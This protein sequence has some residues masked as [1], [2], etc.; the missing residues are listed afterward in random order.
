MWE[1]DAKLP[2][3]LASYGEPFEVISG[4][5]PEDVEWLAAQA[6][7]REK[8]GNITQGVGEG[9]HG[10]MGQRRQRAQ[11][12]R[13]E[14]PLVVEPFSHG[15]LGRAVLVPAR[16]MV[17]EQRFVEGLRGPPHSVVRW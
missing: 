15:R 2:Q 5:V 10:S 3:V 13:V 8:S 4:V 11:T 12:R 1:S 7:C 6:R 9:R 14:K 17:T 16:E